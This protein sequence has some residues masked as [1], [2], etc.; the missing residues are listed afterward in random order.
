[1]VFLD[2]AG[3]GKRKHQ[4][5]FSRVVF[6]TTR[7]FKQVHFLCYILYREQWGFRYIILQTI[8]NGVPD[9]RYPGQTRT[10]LKFRQPDD[11]FH[12]LKTM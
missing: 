10:L 3:G 6:R 9:P 8:V 1:M 12:T 11:L 7:V 4:V 5:T 2:G